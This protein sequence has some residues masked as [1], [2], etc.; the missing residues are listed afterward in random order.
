MTLTGIVLSIYFTTLSTLSGTNIEMK[1]AIHLK[2]NFFLITSKCSCAVQGQSKTTD[3]SCE[4]SLPKLPIKTAIQCLLHTKFGDSSQKLLFLLS[5][6]RISILIHAISM[7]VFLIFLPLPF[8]GLDF[9]KAALGKSDFQLR[10][11][12]SLS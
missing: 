2:K 12:L 8:I 5:L 3:I 10:T 11:P 6:Q 9:L 1:N 4:Y 7:A